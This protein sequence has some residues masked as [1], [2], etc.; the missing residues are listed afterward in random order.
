MGT[1]FEFICSGCGYTAT[2]CGGRDH[3]M[4][5][6]VETM[7]CA[8]CRVLVDVV[9]GKRGEDKL[10]LIGKWGEDRRTEDPE[11]DADIGQCPRCKGDRVSTW[12][13]SMPCPKCAGSMNDRGVR[14]LWD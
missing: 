10:P 8:K 4:R 14:I 7:A 13:P 12:T 1:C 9:T 2:V 11:F 3:G 6:A 5:V